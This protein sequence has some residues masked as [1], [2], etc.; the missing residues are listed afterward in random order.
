MESIIVLTVLLFIFH[1]V[2]IVYLYRSISAKNDAEREGANVGPLERS[3]NAMMPSEPS[4]AAESESGSA[5]STMVSCSVCGAPN[6]PSFQFCRHCVSDLSSG[7]RPSN[8]R[9]SG[10]PNK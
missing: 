7:S 4:D 6:D 1:L 9:R 10:Q 2:I 8:S 5:A 3:T